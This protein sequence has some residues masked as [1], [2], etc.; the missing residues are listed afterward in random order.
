M[1]SK[2]HSGFTIIEMLIVVTILALLAGILIP[3][4][5]QESQRA[6]DGR[7]AGDLRTVAS[8]LATYSSLNGA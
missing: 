6:R 1:R 7:R 3:V 8:A 2:S 5:E 4:L